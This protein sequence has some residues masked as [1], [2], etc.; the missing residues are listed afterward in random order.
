MNVQFGTESKFGNETNTAQ[1]P[2]GPPAFQTLFSPVDSFNSQT[3]FVNQKKENPSAAVQGRYIIVKC[4]APDFSNYEIRN[5]IQDTLFTEIED[6]STCRDRGAAPFGYILCHLMRDVSV[7][8]LKPLH[9]KLFKGFPCHVTLY[10]SLVLFQRAI[11]TICA[12]KID[13]LLFPKQK[14]APLVFILDFTGDESELLSILNACVFDE[15]PLIQYKETG[16][17]QYHVVIYGNEDNALKVARSLDGYLFEGKQL[18]VK[19]VYS[20]AAQR[21]LCVRGFNDEGWIINELKSYG[22]ISQ[23]KKAR[24]GSIYAFMDSIESSKAACAFLNG[25]RHGNCIIRVFFVEYE[26]FLKFV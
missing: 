25:F 20:S 15:Y 9:G 10:P 21:T 24:D 19:C 26:Y 17:V 14:K 11:N 4:G 16:L 6:L 3:Y 13:T 1:I 22:V 18:T 12:S 8:Q 7:S 23:L 2:G 5:F